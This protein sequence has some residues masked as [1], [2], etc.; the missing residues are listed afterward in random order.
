MGRDYWTGYRKMIKLILTIRSLNLG[1]A[2]RQFLEL[3]KHIDKNKFDVYV[4]TMY[5][6]ILED[7]IKAIHDVHYTNLQK[8]G[9]Y[10]LFPFFMKYRSY[11][12]SIQPDVIYS[13]LP[14]MN[15][16]SFWCKPKKTKI[17]WGIRASN[18]QFKQYGKLAQLLFFF[19]KKFSKNVDHIIANSKAAIEFH[20]NQ[21]FK[22]QNFSLVYNGIDI[23]HFIPSSQ[24]ND[25]FR[26]KYGLQ[27]KGIVIAL[28]GRIDIVK[29]HTI[30][31]KVAR[32]ILEMQDNFYFVLIGSGDETIKQ[33]CKAILGNYNQSKTIWIDSVQD[34]ANYYVGLDICCSTSLSESFSN[35]IAE[36]MSCEVPCIVTDVGDSKMIV[37]ECGMVIPPN[38]EQRLYD[39]IMQMVKCDRK[40]LGKQ[41]RKRIKENFSI[42]AMVKNTQDILIKVSTYE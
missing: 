28:V 13:F 15:L 5:G 16:F 20:T 31:A 3:V 32:R 22:V 39:A 19:Q 30:F 42:D 23:N 25:T 7:E 33:E 8:K 14:E 40:Y 18:M 24:K 10:D 29:G 6:G 9:R 12:A 41:S 34:I 1:G 11:L 17:I 21:R 38:D 4:C 35:V 36:A 2:E 27:T 37:G 26:C